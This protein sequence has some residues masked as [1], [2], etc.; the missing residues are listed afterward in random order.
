MNNNKK[1]VLCFNT[2]QLHSLMINDTY[3]D[4]SSHR[5]ESLL[6]Q[7]VPQARSLLPRMDRIHL[8]MQVQARIQRKRKKLCR[9]VVL[10]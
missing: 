3:E 1:Q 5:F 10:I 8:R 4:F 6:Q 7:P 9:L 2:K